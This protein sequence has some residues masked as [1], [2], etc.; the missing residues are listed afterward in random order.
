AGIHSGDQI[1]DYIFQNSLL[2]LHGRAPRA[3]PSITPIGQIQS[4]ILHESDRGVT[5]MM[6][7]LLD[8]TAA[9]TAR[10]DGPQSAAAAA[11]AAQTSTPPSAAAASM[12]P[13]DIDVPTIPSSDA[14]KTDADKSEAASLGQ[15]DFASLL[16]PLITRGQK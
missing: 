3:L 10:F 13:A 6:G 1:A 2:P 7:E 8:L 11:G 5:F 4:A 12:V 9:A 14:H 15:L 16:M